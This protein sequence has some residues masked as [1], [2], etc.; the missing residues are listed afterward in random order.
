MQN[1]K[2]VDDGDG[3]GSAL[4]EN[5]INK[6]QLSALRHRAASF[7]APLGQ[8]LFFSRSI[9][10]LLTTAKKQPDN[11][12]AVIIALL[13]LTLILLLYYHNECQLIMINLLFI[14]LISH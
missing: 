8:S 12:K 11:L 9:L 13:L 6:G 10:L 4:I 14:R 7:F 3:V 2:K 1:D 5:Y